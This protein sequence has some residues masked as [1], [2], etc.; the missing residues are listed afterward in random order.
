MP[1]RRGVVAVVPAKDE[2]QRIGAT[3]R[4]LDS[5]D[6]VL[7]VIV[8]DDGSDDDTRKV[9]HEAG[10]HVVPHPLNVGKAQAMATGLK[11][12]EQLG[13]G[14]SP[15]MFVDADLEDSAANMADLARPVLD[16]E[17]D[18][19]IAILPP[20]Q[21]AGGGRGRVVRLAK[22]GIAERTGWDATQPLSGQRCLT[23]EAVRAVTPFAPGWGVEVGMTIDALDAGLRV[24]E[25]PVELHHRVTGKDLRGVAHRAAQYRDV[26]KALR[27]RKRR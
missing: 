1:V 16:G 27:Q 7:T 26:R 15:V 9:A 24:V 4:A 12:A 23:H 10:A 11:F 17:A 6:E 19:T 20:Q 2:Q 18:L 3:V 5:L 25:V 21:R 8:V 13:Y 22:E 14:Q